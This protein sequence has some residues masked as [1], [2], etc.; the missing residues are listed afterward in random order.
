MSIQTVYLL[1]TVPASRP[2]IAP[3]RCCRGISLQGSGR[4]ERSED[5]ASLLAKRKDLSPSSSEPQLAATT[6]RS[7]AKAN[8]HDVP[9]NI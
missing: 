5:L 3:T 8:I 6:S 4:G 9:R 2:Q 1:S 7:V